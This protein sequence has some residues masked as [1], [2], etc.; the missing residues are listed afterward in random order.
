[1]KKLRMIITAAAVITMLAGCSSTDKPVQEKPSRTSAA[2]SQTAEQPEGTAEA[3]AEITTEPT[4]EAAPLTRAQEILAVMTPEEKVGQLVIGR[5]PG[6]N[7]AQ[8]AQTYHL[9][10]FVMFARDFEDK[11]PEEIRSEIAA[12]Q[13][14][15]AVKML[16]AVDEEGGNVVR[17]SKFAQYRDEPFPAQS[18]VLESG[19]TEGV[20]GDAAE[21]AELL[22]KLGLN[23]NLA[24]VCDLPRDGS[25]YI[26]NRAYST[27]QEEVSSAVG[28]AVSA[29][30]SGNIVCVLKHF[31]GYG[32]NVDTHTGISFDQRPL[33]EFRAL[34]F[35]PFAAGLEQGAPVVMV[36]HNIISCVDDTL[37]GSLS[38]EVY[39]LLREELGFSGVA[40]TDDILMDAI[41]EYCGE[42]EA[43]VRA[44]NAGADLI[45]CT[46]YADA[47]TALREAVVSGE[48]TQERLDESVLRI[49]EIKLEYGIIE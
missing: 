29:Y 26:A 44:F 38:P 28:A 43:A 30:K 24:P 10:G 8:D 13:E 45:C 47:V 49:L 48:I 31:P 1:M 34:D 6:E 32:N 42:D 11:S 40:M 15:S 25:D 7:A 18:E 22:G 4:E 21:K 35:K 12:I 46:G 3:T 41:G 37:P 27:Q 5:F 17:V 9:G 36:S 23:M 16:F 20:Y 14:E 39:R 33:D 2:V 19:G